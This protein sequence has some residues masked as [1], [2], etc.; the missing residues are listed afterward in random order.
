[1]LR[2]KFGKFR[3]FWTRVKVR[4]LNGSIKTGRDGRRILEKW[5]MKKRY[6]IMMY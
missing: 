3:I 4:F 6:Y 5:W 1:M 2:L